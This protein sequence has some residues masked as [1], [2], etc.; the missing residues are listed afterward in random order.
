MLPRLIIPLMPKGAAAPTVPATVDGLVVASGGFG[1]AG[2]STY[3]G[4][5]GGAGG[6]LPFSSYAITAGVPISIVVGVVP[7]QGSNG[8]DSSFGTVIATGGGV[9]G[10]NGSGAGNGGSGGGG[11][12]GGS[13]GTG[14]VGQGHDGGN[15]STFLGGGGGGAGS[16]GSGATPGAGITSSISGV[17]K[18]YS[19]GAGMSYSAPA[20]AGAGPG[21]GGQGYFYGTGSV[22]T[23]GEVTCIY[24]DTQALPAS[25][26]GSPSITTS[27]GY[28]RIT[29]TANGSITF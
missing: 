14:T 3:G 7:I 15:G 4:A 29:W 2:D 6:Y 23:A 16:A 13:G 22:G 9:G 18:T 24:P 11:A 26:T 19:I 8:H 17:S 20:P 5:G 25:T 27:G 1:G 21:C 12:P 28:H 10:Q